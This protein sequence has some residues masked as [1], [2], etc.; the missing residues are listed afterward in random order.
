MVVR[1]LPIQRLRNARTCVAA[2]EALTS[3]SLKLVVQKL[4]D[5]NCDFTSLQARTLQVGDAATGVQTFPKAAAGPP[6]PPPVV[7]TDNCCP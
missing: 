1:A 4:Y 7:G 3:N 2:E 5:T 6:R